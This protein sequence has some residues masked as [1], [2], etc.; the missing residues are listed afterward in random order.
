MSVHKAMLTW[1]PF[2]E[3]QAAPVPPGGC[4]TLFVAGFGLGGG[5]AVGK[6][7]RMQLSPHVPAPTNRPVSSLSREI[8]KRKIHNIIKQKFF[9]EENI[10]A[11]EN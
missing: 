6:T 4:F 3:I 5:S 10:Q 9:I 11:Q 1:K 8:S 7:G 2:Q